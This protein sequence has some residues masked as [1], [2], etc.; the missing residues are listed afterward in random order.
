MAPLSRGF[1]S[2][3]SQTLKCRYNAK[4]LST[5]NLII[6]QDVSEALKNGSPVVSLEST[7]ITHGMPF[8]TNLTMARDV[9]SIIRS[10][11][12]TPATIAIIGGRI[13]VG[14]TDAQL[15]ELAEMKTPAIKTSR[16]DFPYVV[17]NKVTIIIVF[18]FVRF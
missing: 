14:L 6:S 9:E 1:G 7:I 16:R 3:L 15:E 18:F 13:H 17:A 8:P 5:R 4:S 12:A 2:L 11:G 10:G